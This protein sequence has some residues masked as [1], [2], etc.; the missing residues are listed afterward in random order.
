MMLM[1][2]KCVD[3]VEGGIWNMIVVDVLDV[4]G[5]G[6]EKQTKTKM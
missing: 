5:T 4:G 1:L 3:G 2:V 6:K